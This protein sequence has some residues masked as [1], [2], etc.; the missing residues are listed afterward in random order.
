MADTQFRGRWRDVELDSAE[1][2]GIWL[3]PHAG[4]PCQGDHHAVLVPPGGASVWDTVRRLRA[5]LG[6]YAGGNPC[7][8]SRVTAAMDEAFSPIVV[9]TQPLCAEEYRSVGI[10]PDRC[11]YHLDGLHRLIGWS[12]AGRL[13]PALRVRAYVAG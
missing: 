11:L 2:A 6:D 12:L 10:H 5:S 1:L 7:C 4:E 3:P 9:T 8:W 13:T